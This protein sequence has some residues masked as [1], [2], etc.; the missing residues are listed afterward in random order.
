VREVLAG[1]RAPRTSLN[2]PFTGERGIAV[3]RGRL[4]AAIRCARGHHATVND[5]V[6]VVAGRLRDLLSAREERVDGLVLLAAVPVS[7]HRE[8]RGE[9]AEWSSR[10]RS[11]NLTQSRGS[12]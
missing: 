3:V 1:T 10:C 4:D 8:P 5:L 12:G 11:A 2:R 7:L 9:A 6:L